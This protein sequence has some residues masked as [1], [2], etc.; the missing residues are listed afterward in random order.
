[1]SWS[2]RIVELH[3]WTWAG[4][5]WYHPEHG[6]V[7]FVWPVLC[8]LHPEIERVLIPE[9]QKQGIALDYKFVLEPEE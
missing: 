7:T 2:R 8:R 3:G 9:L 4:G 6:S 5:Y 1:M